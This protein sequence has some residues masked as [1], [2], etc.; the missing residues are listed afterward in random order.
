MTDAPQQLDPAVPSVARMYDFMLGGKANYPSDREAVAKLIEIS[1]DVPR[2]ARWNRQFLGRAV[3]FVASRGVTQFLDVGAGLPTQE[4]VHQVA[5][6]IVPQA[7]TVYV[8]ND[9]AVLSQ[10]NALVAGDALTTVVAG[11]VREPADILRDPQVRAA[12]DFSRPVC[13]LLVAILH[14]VPDSYDPG[15]LVAEFRAAL[16]PGSYLILSHATT[17]GSPVQTAA[18]QVDESGAVYDRA[19][20]PL[21]MRDRT[22]V[23]ALLDGFELVEPGLVQVSDWR[24]DE[25]VSD[26][27]WMLGAVGRKVTA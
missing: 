19:T 2:V 9:P 5:R 25:P 10:A 15:G 3:R 14:F 1:P 12:L 26:Y 20:A 27:V 16:A 13:L 22:Q 6:S 18:R 8:D 4:N 23:A 24:P 11:D 17:D 21:A 7:T